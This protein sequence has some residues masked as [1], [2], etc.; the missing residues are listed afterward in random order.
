MII[1]IDIR[2]LQ[3]GHK[4]RGIG[5]VTKQVTNRV[6]AKIAKETDHE[7]IFFEYNDDDPKALLD[8][9]SEL[10]YSSISQGAMPEN[11]KARTKKEKLQDAYRDLYGSPVKGSSATDVYLQFDYAFGVPSD[12]RTI[13]VKHDLIPLIFWEQ[14]FESPWVPFKNY[15]A[16]TTLRTI[17]ANHK[18]TRI[19]NR[20]LKNAKKIIAVS[21]STKNDIQRYSSTPARKISVV[22]LGVDVKASKTEKI[23]TAN[24]I[25]PTKPYLLFV[26]AADAR[27][28]VD[29]L[30]AAYNNLKA[31]GNDIQ[32]VLAGEN[33]QS[34]EKIPNKIVR[35]EVLSSSYKDDILTVGYID[36]ATKKA[37]FSNAIAFVYPTLYEGFGIPVLESMIFSCPV[38]TYSNSSIPEVAGEHALFAKNWSDI[39]LAVE[40]LQQMSESDKND[41]IDAAKVHAE[42]YTWDSTAK[43]FYDI[44]LNT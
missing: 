13:L 12:T 30:V 5:E 29:D 20:S 3:T 36:D 42:K 1:G 15:A 43:G 32:L 28:R 4:Y 33:F 38:I 39:K 35:D 40:K 44:I 18:Y 41:M 14:F 8:I 24:P 23:H 10:K 7:V 9:P 16:R 25:K 37:L 6:I 27:R 34:P 21:S 11:N 26:G 22:P 17:F 2:A 31:E 19:L